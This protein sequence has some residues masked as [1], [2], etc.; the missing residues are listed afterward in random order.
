MEGPPRLASPSDKIKGLIPEHQGVEKD[1]AP[2]NQ[3]LCRAK[4]DLE[5]L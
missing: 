4:A 5:E 2:L 3:N 1:G